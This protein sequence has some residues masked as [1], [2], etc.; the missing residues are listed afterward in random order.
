[1]TI[2]PRMAS[3]FLIFILGTSLPLRAQARVSQDARESCRT[4][5]QA[6]YDWYL[7]EVLK[8]N[9]RPP[10]DLALRYKKGAFD[11]ELIRQLRQDYE[12]ASKVP[13]EI[14]GLDFDPFLNTQDPAD[15]YLVGNIVRKGGSYWAEVFGLVSGKKSDKPD[16]VAELVFN[17]GGWVFVNFH[18]GKSPDSSDMNL[19]SIL[20]SLREERQH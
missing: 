11:S 16:V 2:S 9:G 4:F 6:F 20:K 10:S 15:H 3:W 13:D 5:V 14:V 8:S 18:Y 17:T 12:T 19:L 7:H 1:M